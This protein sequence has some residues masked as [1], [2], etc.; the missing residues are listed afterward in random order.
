MHDDRSTFLAIIDSQC[1]EPRN[2]SH[3]STIIIEFKLYFTYF[4]PSK[5]IVRV[6]IQS[7]IVSWNE[8]FPSFSQSLTGHLNK[9]YEYVYKIISKPQIRYYSEIP[10]KQPNIQFVPIIR[11]QLFRER[12]NITDQI[13]LKLE[14]RAIIYLG[15]VSPYS[16]VA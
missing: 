5:Q 4:K 16:T 8:F 14:K 9:I 6:K 10:L 2:I 13:T 15:L 7:S 11:I 1:V 3:Y 12:P